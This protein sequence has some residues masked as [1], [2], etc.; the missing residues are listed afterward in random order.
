[1]A[2]GRRRAPRFAAPRGG[3]PRRVAGPRSIALADAT[4]FVERGW[5][6]RLHPSGSWRLERA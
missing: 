5:R 6:G 1:V 4:L 2:Q 3:S